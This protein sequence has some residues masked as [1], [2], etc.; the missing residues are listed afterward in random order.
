[1]FRQ[2]SFKKR[3]IAPASRQCV[4]IAAAGDVRD[5]LNA[6]NTDTISA[7]KITTTIGIKKLRVLISE[8]AW[9]NSTPPYE[10]SNGI[11]IP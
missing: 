11:G 2:A 8:Y 7:D 3:D 1:M 4:R 9:V 10:N 5:A 6:G